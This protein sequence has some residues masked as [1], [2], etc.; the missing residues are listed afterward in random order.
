[1]ITIEDIIEEIFGEIEDEHDNSN[2]IEKKVDD[3]TFV[4][5]GRLEIDYLNENYKLNIPESEEY[6]TLAGYIFYNYESLPKMNE[7]VRIGNIHFKVLKMSKTRIEILR[8]EV[9]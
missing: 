1:M 2:L 3:N 6:D 9:Q 7:L 5:S 8:L 4:F